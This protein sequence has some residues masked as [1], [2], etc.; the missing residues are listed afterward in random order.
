MN[1]KAPGT[2]QQQRVNICPFISLSVK[3]SRWER[4][5]SSLR[6]YDLGR[7]GRDC[8]AGRTRHQPDILRQVYRCQSG[9]RA[10]KPK[11][12]YAVRKRDTFALKTQGTFYL[13]VLALGSHHISSHLKAAQSYPPLPPPPAPE[14]DNDQGLNVGGRVTQEA[15]GRW[16]SAIR[17][18]AE[19]YGNL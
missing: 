19:N 17:W 15:L 6:V 4:L 10:T 1:L 13:P 3:R 14:D 9:T 16:G 8:P 12:F 18:A 2:S 5:L 11:H 7:V